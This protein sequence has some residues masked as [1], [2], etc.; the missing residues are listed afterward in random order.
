MT[1]PTNIVPIIE[2]TIRAWAEVLGQSETATS[3]RTYNGLS[4]PFS[5]Q[6]LLSCCGELEELLCCI[7]QLWPSRASWC[8]QVRSRNKL[9]QV[10]RPYIGWADLEDIDSKIYLLASKEKD[11]LDLNVATSD[12]DAILPQIWEFRRQTLEL[13]ATS[14]GITTLALA[15]EGESIETMLESASNETKDKLRQ[16]LRNYLARSWVFPWVKLSEMQTVGQRYAP[17]FKLTNEGNILMSVSSLDI[18]KEILEKAKE[19]LI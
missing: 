8:S 12:V 7:E 11:S 19:A 13:S 14:V 5:A 4:L 18:L 16:I 15:G 6:R 3:S 1:I 9:D 10:F 2:N 17:L